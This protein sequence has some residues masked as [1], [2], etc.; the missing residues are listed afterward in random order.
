M[1]ALLLQQQ[2]VSLGVSPPIP[3]IPPTVKKKFTVWNGTRFNT[4]RPTIGDVAAA[5]YALLPTGIWDEV[6]LL[7]KA[8]EGGTWQ[9]AWDPHP[10]ALSNSADLAKLVSDAAQ[11]HLTITPYVIVRGR[12]EWL[13]QEQAMIRACCTIANRCILN[14][15]PG[16]PYWNGPNDPN[17]IRNNYLKPI[18]VPPTKLQ[19]CAIPRLTQINELGGVPCINAWT[20]PTYVGS[21]SWECYGMIAPLLR[22]DVAIPNLDKWGVTPG[23]Q[24]RIPTTQ[25]GERETWANTEWCEHGMEIWYLDGDI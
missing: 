12:A 8:G 2:Q 4:S 21:A 25:R 23:W 22:V 11:Y 17:F 6:E 14:L 15:E 7:V 10:L 9:A 1:T 19:L 18:G 20:D 5:V 24:Y 16:T 13:P 3:P